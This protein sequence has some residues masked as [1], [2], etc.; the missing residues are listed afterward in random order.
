MPAQWVSV[1]TYAE[2]FSVSQDTVYKWMKAGLL[3]TMRVGRLIRVKPIPPA[4]RR[5]PASLRVV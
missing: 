1:T 5:P 2:T 4:D 3:D